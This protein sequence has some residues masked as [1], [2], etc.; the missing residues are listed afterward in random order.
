MAKTAASS[1]TISTSAA[2]AETPEQKLSKARSPNYPNINLETAVSKANTLYQ[3]YRRHKMPQSQMIQKMDYKA[4]SSVGQ[5]VIAAMKAFGLID[6]EGT[7]PNRSVAVSESAEK[8]VRSHPERADLLRSAALAPKIHREV[9]DK[10]YAGDEPSPPDV[11]KHYLEWDRPGG[12]FTPQAL[13]QF[14]KQFS[15]TVTFA[16]LNSS[17]KLLET[18]GDGG[19]DDND[20]KPP[21][22]PPVH[23]KPKPMQTAIQPGMKQA[24]L[25]LD[26]GVIVVQWPE[27]LTNDEYKDIS[28]WLKV[29]DRRIKRSVGADTGAAQHEE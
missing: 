12:T 22:Q 23:E 3:A 26:A 8:I 28:D 6:I 14:L 11:I 10:F 13:G 4:D 7:G 5:Q 16:Q 9:W 27:R 21:Q 24:A 15:D 20:Q 2:T 19:V 17:A 29:V 1:S 25:D 18:G